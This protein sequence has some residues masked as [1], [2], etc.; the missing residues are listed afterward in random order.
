MSELNLIVGLGNPGDQYA[1][2]RHNAGVWLVEALAK[3]F[4]VS[5]SQQS[6]FSGFTTRIQTSNSDTILLIPTTYMNRS[7]IAV[8]AV[9]HF[10][11]IPPQRILVAHDELDLSVG[12][13]RFKQAGGHGGHN[14]L[15]DIIAH[16]GA[17][18]ARCRIGIGHPGTQ[19]EVTHYVLHA[20]SKTEEK[21]IEEAMD[22]TL[23][24]KNELLNLSLNKLMN[25]CNQKIKGVSN[26]I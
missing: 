18:F 9:A 20:P 3:S 2:T 24:Y 14:G 19:A 17:D 10:Y 13:I 5:W 1:R 12:A 26:G 7:G 25:H 16:L 11:Q 6:K 4:S 23:T 22:Q 21:M 8:Q 15:R